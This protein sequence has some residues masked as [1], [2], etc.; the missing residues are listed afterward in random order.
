MPAL[1]IRHKEKEKGPGKGA[2][3]ALGIIVCVEKDLLITSL[4]S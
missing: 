3:P 2:V 4:F 1:G